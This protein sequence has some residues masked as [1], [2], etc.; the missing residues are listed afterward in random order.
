MAKRRSPRRLLSP[1][2]GALVAAA[3]LVGV[4][5][6]ARAQAGAG[7][8]A[9]AGAGAGPAHAQVN[10][11]YVAP[12]ELG[13]PDRTAFASAIATRL[14]YDAIRSASELDTLAVTFTREPGSPGPGG[15]PSSDPPL[16]VVMQRKRAD[17][18]VVSDK[19]LT[20]E[21]GSCADLAATAAFSA[22]ILL[23]PRVM[24]APRPAPKES[25]LESSAAAASPSYPPRDEA[26][27]TA[28]G[29]HAGDPLRWRGL[30][31]FGLC[32]GC[33]PETS[34][35]IGVAVGIAKERF[36]LDL[37]ARVDLP[38]TAS[39]ASREIGASLVAFEVFPHVRV[40]P[41]RAGPLGAVG[42]LLGESG[43]ERQT[44]PWGGAGARVGIELWVARPVFV[45]VA[46]DGLLVLGRVALRAEGR[47][48]WSSPVAV[49]GGNV[50]I[51]V[52][53]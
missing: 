20:A 16:A 31:S 46:L 15:R 14:G 49:L 26:S 37:G 40:G 45:R 6:E 22:A 52:E 48:L 24:L 44:S 13:C 1:R 19:R 2:A 11:A 32:T 33:A 41:L 36:G 21:S 28:P 39:T 23:D 43:G 25:T 8:G 53:L 10:L 27:I 38:A 7:E 3:A 17:G 4:T 42:A 51:G 29:R 47:E 9:A 30:A 5:R 50:G 34:A 35:G 12:P 18:A